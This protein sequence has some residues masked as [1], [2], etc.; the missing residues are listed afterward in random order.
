VHKAEFNLTTAAARVS[1]GI[2]AKNDADTRRPRGCG[3]TY[4]PAHWGNKPQAE[5]EG[6][7]TTAGRLME[8]KELGQ[9]RWIYLKRLSHAKAGLLNL[10]TN[11]GLEGFKGTTTQRSAGCT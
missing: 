10:E 2:T 9:C 6:C 8:G 5:Q 4:L 7:A 11:W 1:S 3:K